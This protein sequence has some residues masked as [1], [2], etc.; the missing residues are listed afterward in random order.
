[1]QCTGI[2]M[3]RL[4]LYDFYIVHIKLEEVYAGLVGDVETRFYTSIYQ[5]KMQLP[6]G[7]NKKVI[8]L[9]KDELSGEIMKEI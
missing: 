8:G 1:M 2:G 3:I 7:K 5:V 4:V 6:M 9:M